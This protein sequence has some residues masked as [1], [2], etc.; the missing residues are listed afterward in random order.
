MS[1]PKEEYE[2]PEEEYEETEN[3]WKPVTHESGRVYYWNTKTNETTALGAPDP[4]APETPNPS[5][6]QRA[7]KLPTTAAKLAYNSTIGELRNGRVP[8]VDAI[9]RTGYRK[10]HNPTKP[11]VFEEKKGYYPLGGKRTRKAKKSSSKKRKTSHR[12]GTKN[13]IKTSSKRT[14]KHN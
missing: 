4:S 13:A 10:W 9:W 5:W 1:K 8:I 14:R 11:N 7:K 3:P 12:K 2:E 6:Y